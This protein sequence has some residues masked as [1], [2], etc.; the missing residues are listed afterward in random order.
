MLKYRKKT[1]EVGSR[2]KQL[3]KTF[4]WLTSL[5]ILII[6]IRIVS[7]SFYFQPYLLE[8]GETSIKDIYLQFDVDVLDKEE[9]ERIRSAV[10]SQY[11]RIYNYD[12][13][14]FDRVTKKANDITAAAQ[15]LNTDA[16]MPDLQKQILLNKSIN[17]KYSF[18]LTPDEIKTLLKYCNDSEFL[19]IF[20]MILKHLLVENAII[21]GADFFKTFQKMNVISIK[22]FKLNPPIKIT[23]DVLIDKNTDLKNYLETFLRDI[24][25]GD[26]KEPVKTLTIKLCYSIIEPNLIFNWEE[27]SKDKD[28]KIADIKLVYRHFEKGEKLISRG[29]SISAL[30]YDAL[31]SINNKIRN[32][33]IFTLL[34][35]V[36]FVL[37][38]FF[39]IAFYIK[40]FR[41]DFVFNSSNIFV[42]SL[43]ILLSLFLG[44]VLLLYFRETHL[45]IAG[46]L[47]PA[48]VIGML[49]VILLEARIAF[50]LV[51]WG[52]LLFGITLDF[53]NAYRFVLY[54]LIGGFTAIGFLYTIKERKDVLMAGMKLAVVNAISI[55]VINLI[56]DPFNL[57]TEYASWGIVNGLAC[58]CITM[59]I[60][61]FIEHFFGIITDVRL[62]ELTGIHQPILKEFEEK[63]PGSYQHTLN[64]A[65]LADAAAVAIGARY[66]LARAGAYYH[67]LGK[68]TKP[69][70]FTENQ[71]TAEDKKTHSKI[72]PHMSTLIIKNHIRE[73][74]EIAK[75]HK[76]P[77]IIIDFIPQHHGT[78]M[79]KYFYIQAMQNFQNSDSADP[80]R[81]ED[82]RYPGPKPQ[83]I[84]AAIVMLADSVEATITSKLSKP[85]VK[86]DDIRR[87][88]RDTISGKF[89]DGQFDECD[90]TLKDLHT[91]SESFVKSFLS[92]FHQRIDYPQSPVKKD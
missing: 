61:P 88:V 34:G 6:L 58:I 21:D 7:P 27:S 56:E 43:P 87:V 71:V 82:F 60:V 29:Q 84:E 46:Y 33:K 26:G 28:K 66:L 89:N 57:H 54:S 48:G 12:S 9:T 77:Q 68:M 51:L 63:S 18:E 39:I 65:K 86:E 36:T 53:A 31:M 10:E 4:P 91:I 20:N 1:T 44:R 80:V 2:R 22:P 73:G 55:I 15:Q 35:I 59:P 64:V 30:Q 23:T 41:P 5:I 83:S 19:R 52:S 67:D 14:A 37:L 79:I 49:G 70:Y 75:K 47:F 40:K 38:S 92:R 69:K 50:I 11:S 85:F 24:F 32:L 62:L 8:K 76:I 25:R 16:N 45:E 90:L 17:Q 3:R 74:I 13:D 72:S 81:E 42:V 78:G